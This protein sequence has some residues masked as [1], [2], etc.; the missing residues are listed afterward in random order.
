MAGY[1][2]A[3]ITLLFIVLTF[4]K[5]WRTFSDQF[6]PTTNKKRKGDNGQSLTPS[7]PQN[8]NNARP[9]PPDLADENTANEDEHSVDGD[10]LHPAP[11]SPLPSSKRPKS[12]YIGARRDL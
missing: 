10:T 9:H 6:T 5:A 3:A 11:S 2:F 4:G 8:D 7:P 1:Y 12:R